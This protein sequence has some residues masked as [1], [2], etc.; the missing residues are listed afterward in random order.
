MNPVEPTV[1][2]ATSYFKAMADGKSVPIT[3]EN[4]RGLGVVRSPPMYH[5][6]TPTNQ[7]LAQARETLKREKVIRGFEGESQA[8]K[9]KLPQKKK[10][11]TTRDYLMPGLE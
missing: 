11:K 8:K 2:Q 1:D 10:K 6:T 9:S 7:V 4:S 5:V 3:P